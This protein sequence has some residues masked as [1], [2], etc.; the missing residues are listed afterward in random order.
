MK[1]FKRLI[2]KEESMREFLAIAS[3]RLDSLKEAPD[4]A[5]SSLAMGDGVMIDPS[6]SVIVSPVDAQVSMVFSSK[7]AFGLKTKDGIELLVHIG[8]DTVNLKG[9]G[10]FYKKKEGD[11]VK[12]G[13]I[14]LQID[15]EKIKSKGYDPT[16]MLVVTNSNDYNIH[17]I[18]E[19]SV[20]A[21]ETV[22]SNY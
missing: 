9:E 21:G 11:S 1:W 18:N 17:F 19:S 16:I 10:F 20:K 8:I 7:H 13:D 6:D 15:R 2:Q 5:F 12:A 14:I 3:G 22:I 4:A